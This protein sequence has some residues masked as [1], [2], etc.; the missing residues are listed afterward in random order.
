MDHFN[1]ETPCVELRL[2]LSLS[3]RKVCSRKNEQTTSGKIHKFVTPRI[4]W[5]KI[6]RLNNIVTQKTL[7]LLA[8]SKREGYCLSY[9]CVSTVR[10]MHVASVVHRMRLGAWTSGT[11]TS[12]QSDGGRK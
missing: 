5:A 6:V 4:T 8:N 11:C 9:A 3:T 10:P 12:E 7:Y 2:G 1:H